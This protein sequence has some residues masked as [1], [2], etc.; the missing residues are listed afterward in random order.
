MITFFV[1]GLVIFTIKIVLFSIRAAWSIVKILLVVLGV[2]TLLIMLIIIGL[3]HVA[4]PL[5][6][7]ALLAAFI[8]PRFMGK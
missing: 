5:L 2:P 7:V 1:I 6:I 4:A 3:I 8:V